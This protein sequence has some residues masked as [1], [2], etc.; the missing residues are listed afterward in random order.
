M[1]CFLLWSCVTSLVTRIQRNG[2]QPPVETFELTRLG[3]FQISY[4]SHF[5]TK[6]AWTECFHLQP[7][8]MTSPI[9]NMRPYIFHRVPLDERYSVTS[10]RQKGLFCSSS[11][12]NYC[13]L[14]DRSLSLA[15]ER[16]PPASFPAFPREILYGSNI[17]NRSAVIPRS[18]HCRSLRAG[19]Q[20][21]WN[22]QHLLEICQSFS[23]HRET[24]N[25]TAILC[26]TAR[27]TR[28][29]S[30]E[31]RWRGRIGF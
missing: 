4:M 16:C 31:D 25:N 17:Q 30:A 20:R 3:L 2:F 11:V 6:Y 14:P 22:L 1:K 28:I 24:R 5:P 8:H 9:C 26:C 29:T 13:W 15:D 21:L 19:V 12:L 27:S 18:L 10:T 7:Q 23:Q